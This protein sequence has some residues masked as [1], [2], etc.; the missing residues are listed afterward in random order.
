MKTQRNILAAFLLNLT[1]SVFEFVGGALTGSVAI[2][3][4]ALHDIGD[5]ASIGVSFFLEKKSIQPPDGTYTYG[6]VR[7]SVIGGFITS[8]VLLVSSVVIIYNAACRILVPTPIHYDRMIFFAVVGVCVNFLAA[9]LTREGGSI[10]Q[11]AVNLHM[12]EDVLG[13]VIVLVGGIIMRFTNFY[14]LDPI[15]S[16]GVSVFILIHTFRNLKE[17]FNLFLE[18]VPHGM[19]VA[20]VKAH[21]DAIDGV[22]DAHH[23]HLWSTD[24]QN[25]IATMHIVTDR[26]GQKIKNAVREKLNRLGIGHVTM[27]LETSSEHCHALSCPGTNRSCCCHR[28]SH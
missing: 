12:L 28:H 4:D 18:K 21:V 3:S 11:R 14:L 2:L 16:I 22:L 6:Y 27:E 15:M 20:S 19:D 25:H 26:E 10:N 5:A 7:Y 13:W 9:L 17:I 23:I 1:F 8:L 24:G